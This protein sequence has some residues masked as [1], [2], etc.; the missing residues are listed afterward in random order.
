[1]NTNKYAE[2]IQKENRNLRLKNGQIGLDGA[3]H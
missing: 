2:N 3:F 1:M